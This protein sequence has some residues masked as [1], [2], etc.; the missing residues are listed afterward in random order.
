MSGEGWRCASADHRQP[1]GY[2]DVRAPD[3]V[4]R[5]R[6]LAGMPFHIAVT[7]ANLLRGAFRRL[8]L[9][10]LRMLTLTA[11][12]TATTHTFTLLRK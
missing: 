10:K 2:K 6:R 7:L 9:L 4:L 1:S 12:T 3:L 8:L 5:L 11:T